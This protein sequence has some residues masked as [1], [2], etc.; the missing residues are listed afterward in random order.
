MFLLL[1]HRLWQQRC[2]PGAGGGPLKGT[3]CSVV[4][5]LSPG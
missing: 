4:I 5:F 1:E 3:N 2:F